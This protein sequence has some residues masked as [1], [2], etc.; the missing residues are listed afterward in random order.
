MDEGIVLTG[1][2]NASIVN[3]N[4]A[5]FHRLF[6]EAWKKM[7]AFTRKRATDGEYTKVS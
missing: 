7:Y 6:L 4:I 3:E 5:A 2:F 1:R